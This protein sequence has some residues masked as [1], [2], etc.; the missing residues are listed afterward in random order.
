MNSR[1]KT[2]LYVIDDDRHFIYG[3]SKGLKIADYC[4]EVL[5]FDDPEDALEAIRE[6]VG[7]EKELPDVIFLDINMPGLDGWEFLDE[8]R[9]IQKE[10]AHKIKVYMVSSSVMESDMI[11]ALSYPE[12]ETYLTKPLSK[13]MLETIFHV[14]S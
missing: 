10:T 8:L 6:K 9:I 11:K 7:K 14:D 3:V 12:V 13:E 5:F 1:L 4:S 2:R